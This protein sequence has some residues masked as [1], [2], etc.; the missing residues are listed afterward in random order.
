MT[1]AALTPNATLSTLGL[2]TRFI[3]D[4]LMSVYDNASTGAREDG[5]QWYDDAQSLCADLAAIAPYSTDQIAT[6]IAAHSIRTQWVRNKAAA[7]ATV[8]YDEELPGIMARNNAWAREA[9][10]SANPFDI[11]KGDKT[12]RFARNIAGD[13]NSVTVDVWA[14]RAAGIPEKALSR[15]GV[16]EAVERC[17]QLSANRA[18]ITPRDFQA[19]VWVAIRG[20]SH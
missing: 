2:S 20:R 5:A 19:I 1:T 14:A 11:L 16:Y 8:L 18:G 4:R 15:K 9:L 6:A 7:I 3:T 13:T 17:Y 12:N 10:S